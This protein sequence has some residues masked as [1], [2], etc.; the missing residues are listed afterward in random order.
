MK[1]PKLPAVAVLVVLAPALCRAQ[2]SADLPAQART[3]LTRATEYL[4]SISEEGGYLWRYAADMKRRAGE[5]IATPTQVWVQPPGTPSMGQTFLH[6]YAVT[7]DARYLD[8]ARAAADALARGQLESGGWDYLIEF[9]PA[10]RARWKYRVDPPHATAGPTTNAAPRNTSTFDDDNTQSALQFL[11]AFVDVA[12]AGPADPR[13]GRIRETLEYG[14]KRMLDAQ[15]P[16]GAWPQRWTGDAHDPKQFPVL[17]ATI[18]KEYP[19]EQPTGSYYQ[20][21]TLNDNTQRDCIQTLLDAHRRTGKAEYLEAARHGADFLLR[22]QLPEPQP[23]WAQQYD[24]AMHPAWARA[25]EPPA[26]TAGE[27]VG[28]INMLIDFYLQTGDEKYIKRIPEAIAWYKRSQISPGRWARLYE[29]TTNRPI[30]GDRDK[31]IHYTLEEL[32]AERRT[33]YN[34][35]NNWGTAVIEH[36]EAVLK[37]GREKWLADHADKPLSAE[38]R[39]SR[40]NAMEP[41]VREIISQLDTQGRWLSNNA[42]RPFQ[43]DQ[44]PWV[45]MQRAENNLRTLCEYLEVAPR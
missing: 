11:L 26:A 44:G 20:H 35:Q 12:K 25:F 36:A 17:D 16:I 14:L 22:A 9:D 13:D 3:T 24:A 38:E 34:W 42:S 31:K 10:Q 32:S 29:L 7:R 5:E 37:A 21:Y 30:Y 27:S 19:R 2:N 45:E 40:A 23:V 28:A 18:P 39:T 4:R 41:R 1:I 8:A 15:Y 6:A 43:G 33:G